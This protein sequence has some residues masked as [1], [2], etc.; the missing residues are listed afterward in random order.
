MV[1]RTGNRTGDRRRRRIREYHS[2]VV[3]EGLVIRT[4]APDGADWGV[5]G[6]KRQ[7]R[8]DATRSVYGSTDCRPRPRAV[9][10]QESL[11]RPA[12]RFRPAISREA[13]SFC[14]ETVMSDRSS[15]FG[16]PLA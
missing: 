16:L 2:R 8:S 10:R 4:N 12:T 7:G 5:T 15:S 14:H 1:S 9:G 3:A 13:I 6:S 11:R